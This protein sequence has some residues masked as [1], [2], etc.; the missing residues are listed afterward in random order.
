MKK[1]ILIVAMLMSN[2]VFGAEQPMSKEIITSLQAA[3]EKLERLEG[4]FPA[5]DEEKLNAN[6][7]DTK[8]Q[9]ALIEAAGATE[10]VERAIKSV[11]FDDIET[12]I[13]YAQRMTSS[14]FAVMQEQMPAGMT[15]GDLIKQQESAL[16]SMKSSG[17][18]EAALQEMQKGIADMKTQQSM[19]ENAVSHAKSEDIA[20]MRNN[21]P[22]VMQQFESGFG[23]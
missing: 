15:M 16:E 1:L 20:F 23:G 21:F 19:M 14:M 2:I 8:A 22:W 7:F 5:L 4:K 6:M 3:M 18:P 17:L 13:N 12:F 9:L 11:G 10:A